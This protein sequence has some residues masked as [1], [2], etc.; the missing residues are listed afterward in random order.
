VAT[1]AFFMRFYR[2][3]EASLPKAEALQATRI[4]MAMVRSA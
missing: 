3:L 4:A 1:S 2:N